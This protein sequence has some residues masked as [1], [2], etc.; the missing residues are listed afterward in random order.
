MEL[1]YNNE[2]LTVEN[3]ESSILIILER[4]NEFISGSDLIFSHLLV[5]EVEV[6]ENHEKYINDRL[7]EIKKVE[8]VT[9]SRKDMI[10]KTMLSISSYLE[11]AIPALKELTV[12]SYERFNNGTWQGIDQLAEG[13]QWILQFASSIR[14]SSPK[15]SNW[16]EVENCLQV[17]EKSFEL[18]LDGVEMKDKVLIS[19]VLTYEVTPAYEQLQTNIVILLNNEE[20]LKDVN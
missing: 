10:M 17:C 4:I 9:L 5:D 14:L 8:I 7:Y 3:D 6:Y 19:D 12:G 1:K 16:T 13:M 20:S 11:R 15:L 18:L 2:I